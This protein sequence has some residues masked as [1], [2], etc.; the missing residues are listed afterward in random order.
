[1]LGGSQIGARLAYRLNANPSRP[2]A[3]SA[4][5]YAP[6]AH[7]RSGLEVAAGVDWKP[8]KT[9]PLHLLAERRQAVGRSGR[10]AFSLTAYGGESEMRAGPVRIDAYGQAGIVGLHS[11]DLFADGSLRAGVPVRGGK[12]GFGLWAAAQPGAWRADAG[13]QASVRL[14]VQRANIVLIAD[15]RFRIAGD[16]NP[17]SGPSLTLAA[18]F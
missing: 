10:S 7:V 12:V 9:L 18:D 11:H 14:P 4:R 1:M 16:A 6:L 13:P 5:I 17:R 3:A 2:L 8:V 15:W